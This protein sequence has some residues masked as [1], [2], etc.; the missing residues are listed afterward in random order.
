MTPYAP[1][2]TAVTGVFPE[3]KSRLEERWLLERY[4]E[5]GDYRRRVRRESVP[6]LR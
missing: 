4:P 6:G 2:A 3:L 5:Y 1:A